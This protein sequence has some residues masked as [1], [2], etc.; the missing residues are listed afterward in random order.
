[1]RNWLVISALSL[2]PSVVAVLSWY[3][4]WRYSLPTPVPGQY[5]S[6]AAKDHI[7]LTGKLKPI[8]NLP[9][10]LHFFNPGCPCSKFNIPQFRFL[11]TEYA[12]KISFAVIVM[13]EDKS[14][15]EK[16]IQEKYSV[17]TVVLFDTSLAGL[18]GIYFTPQ[19]VSPDKNNT[20]YF[21]GNLQVG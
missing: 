14:Y 12:G 13:T 20:L 3:N 15:T 19:A 21:R 7:D 17:T 2:I 1:M 10:F 9:V 18:F 16:K 4:E 5:H 11:A 8:G 6:V